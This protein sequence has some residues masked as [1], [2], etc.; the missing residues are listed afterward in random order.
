M[1]DINIRELKKIQVQAITGR[2][3]GPETGNITGNRAI[4][5]QGMRSGLAARLFSKG[6]E[7]GKIIIPIYS[8]FRK[9]IL[10]QPFL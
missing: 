1:N 2:G 8:R 10:C 7:F 6:E 9:V 3:R 4:W 5:L